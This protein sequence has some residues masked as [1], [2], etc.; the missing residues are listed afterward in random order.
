MYIKK[1]QKTAYLLK[2]KQ[3][4]LNAFIE[5]NKKSRLISAALI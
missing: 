5:K 4:G 3:F 2:G 1:N